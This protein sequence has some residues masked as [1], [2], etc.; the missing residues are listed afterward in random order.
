MIALA[1]VAAATGLPV[2][3]SAG[4]LA[5]VWYGSEMLLAAAAGWYL[6]ALYPI[7]V[8]MR[9]LLLPVLW[10][11]AWRGSA[12]VWRGNEMQVAKPGRAA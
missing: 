7:H 12:F 9:D 2:F 6:P 1:F 11:S 3:A 4:T 10:I 5:L 8:L